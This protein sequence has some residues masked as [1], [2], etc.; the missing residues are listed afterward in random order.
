M[1]IAIYKNLYTYDEGF[2]SSIKN[3]YVSYL[4]ETKREKE[5]NNTYPY[6]D[7]YEDLFAKICMRMWQETKLDGSLNIERFLCEEKDDVGGFKLNY[8]LYL[9]NMVVKIFL[10]C[11]WQEF[12]DDVIP[13]TKKFLKYLTSDREALCAKS[14]SN[15]YILVETVEELRSL[16]QMEDSDGLKIKPTDTNVPIFPFACKGDFITRDKINKVGNEKSLIYMQI[17]QIINFSYSIGMPLYTFSDDQLDK[18]FSKCSIVDQCFIRLS[19][20]FHKAWVEQLT[21]D[22]LT[23]F[24]EV[25][26]KLGNSEHPAYKRD[27]IH[28]I[29]KLNHLIIDEFQD[30]SKCILQFLGQLKTHLVLI[31]ISKN[32]SLTCVGDDYQSIYGWRGSSAQFILKF[33]ECFNLSHYPYS[34]SFID[35][36]R[37]AALILEAGALVTDR[38]RGGASRKGYRVK[39][40]DN[41]ESEVSCQF[42]RGVI[43]DGNKYPTLDFERAIEVL[44]TEISR[45]EPTKD[46]PIYLL[47][48]TRSVWK[49]EGANL[50]LKFIEMYEKT[51][52][53]KRLTIHSSKGL[54]GKCV[55]VLGDI[56]NPDI[57]PVRNGFYEAANMDGSYH[58]MQIDEAYRVAYV[59]ITRAKSN[60][61]WFF[62]SSELN[63]N[64]ISFLLDEKKFA[65]LP[66]STVQSS[67]ALPA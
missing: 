14:A 21:L 43:T 32:G 4:R 16:I 9:P 33:E 1:Q 52:Q 58:N 41:K 34:N 57:H 45:L 30:I 66:L 40:N 37:S 26:Y 54:E 17:S 28:N 60:L 2:R 27:D 20:T 23:T 38:I 29:N 3:L 31:Q 12:G 59:G 50:F 25:F 6:T 18:F 8:H 51:G 39:A 65:H 48:T 56:R 44:K 61:H 7:K 35:N 63:N 11:T 5:F 49:K 42:Y 55:I 13:S 53:L 15:N 62:I 24:D 67:K 36:Y 19:K 10:N 46:N 22:N 47:L 64:L